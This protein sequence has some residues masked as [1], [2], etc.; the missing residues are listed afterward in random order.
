MNIT[1]ELNFLALHDNKLVEKAKVFCVCKDVP[2][3]SEPFKISGNLYVPKTSVLTLAS[4]RDLEE[5]EEENDPV[6]EELLKLEF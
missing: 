3:I 5:P 2:D 1:D 6:F 4:Y